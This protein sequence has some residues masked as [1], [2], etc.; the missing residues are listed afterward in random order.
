MNSSIQYPQL[1]TCSRWV[2]THSHE[3]MLLLCFL[4]Y[5]CA[6]W[7]LRYERLKGLYRRYNC[8]SFSSPSPRTSPSSPASASL[9]PP[10]FGSRPPPRLS[11]SRPR[12]LS[13]MTANEAFSIHH[14]LVHLE[15]PLV[16]STATMFALF[17]ASHLIYLHNSLHLRSLIEIPFIFPFIYLII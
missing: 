1:T 11:K 17:K 14:D 7:G 15:F 3:M 8:S 10:S 2:S 13:Q 9:P 12:P 5:L 4:A 6:V 16:F